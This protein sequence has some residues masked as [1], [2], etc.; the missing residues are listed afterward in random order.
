[1]PQ[2]VLCRLALQFP[3]LTFPIKMESWFYLPTFSAKAA[4]R[5]ASFA[6]VGAR[7]ALRSLKR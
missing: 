2:T 4:S 1:M 5:S 3:I 7:F 6:V